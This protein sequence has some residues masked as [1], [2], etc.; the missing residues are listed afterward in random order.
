MPTFRPSGKAVAIAGGLALALV[1]A[2]TTGAVAGTLITS[3]D[4]ENHTIQTADLHQDSV[5]T[6]NIAPG[7]VTWGKSLSA[8]AK[9]TIEGLLAEGTPGSTGS[10]GPAGPAGET[11]AAGPAGPQG[12]RGETGPAGSGQL[13]EYDLFVPPSTLPGAEDDSYELEPASG[14]P[15]ELTDPGTYLVT[16]QGATV[17]PPVA[18]F[19]SLGAGGTDPNSVLNGCFA[20]GTL[21]MTPP[22]AM[23]SVTYTIGVSA[24]A[25]LSLPVYVNGL[26]CGGEGTCLAPA[27]AKVAIY[28][29]SSAV[30]TEPT[31][32]APC[33]SLSRLAAASC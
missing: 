23:C 12:S 19:I 31:L 14:E 8:N 29:M 33:P 7:S 27:F 16:I 21:D 18:S 4:I 24:D 13:V 1:V 26:N 5:K 32:P 20:S 28:K 2:A 15:I 3:K 6:R 9:A 10:Q 22:V 11:G 30:P 25:P 17:N